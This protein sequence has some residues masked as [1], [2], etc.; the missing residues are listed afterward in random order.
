MLKRILVVVNGNDL[1]SALTFTFLSWPPVASS[2]PSDEKWQHATL[3][4]LART[5]HISV[6]N[7]EDHVQQISV[8]YTELN[9]IS[10]QVSLQSN[11]LMFKVSKSGITQLIIQ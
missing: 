9:S 1:L 2:L 4:A 10:F 3:L 11:S 7:P 8:I 6:N 5:E